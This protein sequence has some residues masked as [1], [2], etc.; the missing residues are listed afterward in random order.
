MFRIGIIMGKL[1]IHAIY[2]L[3]KNPSEET[4]EIAQTLLSRLLE[5]QNIKLW[6]EQAW[7]RGMFN[8]K[9]L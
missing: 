6:T 7:L 4:T 2:F 5:K 3:K 8:G 1:D 9:L